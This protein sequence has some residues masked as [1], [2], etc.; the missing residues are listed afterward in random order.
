MYA[1]CHNMMRDASPAPDFVGLIIEHSLQ[2]RTTQQSRYQLSASSSPVPTA[3][4][5]LCSLSVLSCFTGSAGPQSVNRKP[6]T[7]KGVTITYKLCCWRWVGR[8]SPCQHA[9]AVYSALFVRCP[10]N[11][12]GRIYYVIKLQRDGNEAFLRSSAADCKHRLSQPC[13]YICF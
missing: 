1:L 5:V 7:Q 8:Q 10:R 9:C 3:I 11:V 2:G 12:V 6:R 13:P 4:C